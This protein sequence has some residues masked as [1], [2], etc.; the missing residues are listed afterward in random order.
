MTVAGGIQPQGCSLGHADGS[1]LPGKAMRGC[2][3]TGEMPHSHSATLTGIF[4]LQNWRERHRLN[5]FP[6]AGA[7]KC[8]HS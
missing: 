3:V 7:K 2:F 1:R 4:F 6:L 5:P 8:I